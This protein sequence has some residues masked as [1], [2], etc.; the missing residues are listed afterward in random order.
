LSGDSCYEGKQVWSALFQKTNLLLVE[1]ESEFTFL[2]YNC[3]S[4]VLNVLWTGR[5]LDSLFRLTRRCQHWLQ[6]CI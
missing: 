3:I 5:H 1:D 6:H 2:F 4:V